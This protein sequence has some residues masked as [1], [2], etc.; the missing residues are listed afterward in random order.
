MRILAIDASIRST[1][2]TVLE[3]TET[4]NHVS[5]EAI[6]IGKIVTK[7]TADENIAI[8]IAQIVKELIELAI[9]YQVD[10]VE[11]EDGF[12]GKNGKTALLLSGLRQSI[13]TAFYLNHIPV[14]TDLPSAIR[15]I[16]MGNGSVDKQAI[17]EHIQT[18]FA[19]NHLI[20]SI[21]VFRDKGKSKND[22]IY[23][24]ISIGLARVLKQLKP[25]CTI[26][27]H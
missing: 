19:E 18:V 15:S 20:Q 24:S 9:E 5:I 21:G 17:A 16:V 12:V 14:S 27:Y 10:E 23:D 11:L 22:D 8:T 13:I 6:K 7:K 25:N 1:G 3:Y 26:Y 4:S 2:Y